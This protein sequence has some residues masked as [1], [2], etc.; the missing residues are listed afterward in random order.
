ML[1]DL[2]LAEPEILLILPVVPDVDELTR[3]AVVVVTGEKGLL[4]L[5]CRGNR[6][7]WFPSCS[8]LFDALS[9]SYFF[10]RGFSDCHIKQNSFNVR[11]TYK[12]MGRRVCPSFKLF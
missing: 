1:E 3:V 12:S 5:Q 6:R 2:H 11:M 10:F 4:V 9:F 7:D 8:S